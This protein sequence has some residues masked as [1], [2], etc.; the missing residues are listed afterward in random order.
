MSWLAND[1]VCGIVQQAYSY[2]RRPEADPLMHRGSTRSPWDDL[3]PR[4]GTGDCSS[5]VPSESNAAFIVNISGAAETKF[6]TRTV[7]GK[8]GRD[9]YGA[10]RRA[11]RVNSTIV[12]SLRAGID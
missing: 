9:K 8:W 1:V 12:A 4:L 5:P 2:H 11:A 7:L 3:H 10:Q 6:A